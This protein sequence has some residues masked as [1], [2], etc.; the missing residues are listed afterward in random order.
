M[1]LVYLDL[2]EFYG[3]FMFFMLFQ[4]GSKK[5]KRRR[6]AEQTPKQLVWS[7]N[8]Q[9]R[10]QY[11]VKHLKAVNYFHKEML[12]VWQSSEY[13]SEYKHTNVA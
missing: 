1:Y 7:K 6:K 11:P 8:T 3:L 13:A 9:R 2:Y 5:I 12:D 10:I 4:L